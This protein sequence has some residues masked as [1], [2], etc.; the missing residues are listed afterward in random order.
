M[1]PF[2]VAEYQERLERVRKNMEKQG[3]EVLLITDPANM[4]YLSGY[5]AWSFYVHQMLVVDLSSEQ[6]IWIGRF[7]DSGAARVTTWMHD[8]YIIGYPDT[9]VHSDVLHPMMYAA[10][11]LKLKGL[12]NKRI[13]VEMDHYYF[14]A[15]AYFHLQ[16]ELPDADLT[17]ADLLV[18][19]VRLI[20]SDQEIEYMKKAARLAE[21]AMT[22][23]VNSIRAGKRECDA[24]AMIYYHM[25]AG[26][27]DISGD[28]P[29][30][31]P[32]LP[33]GKNTSNPHLTW[34]DRTFQEGETV[35][36]ELAGCCKRYHVPLARTVTIGAP[37]KLMAGL[38]SVAVEGLNKVLDGIKPGMTCG[39]AEAL[40]RKAL[41]KHGIV[42]E[43]RLGY[44]VGLNY[45]PDWGEHTASIRNGDRTVLKP[46]MTFH[47]IPGL[48]F[49]DYG[50]EISETIRITENGCETFTSFPRE[51][52]INMPSAFE[53]HGE[54]S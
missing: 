27:K 29:A 28:Y 15:K 16:K 18:N 21:T 43:S 53:E 31:V 23:G 54:I 35:I 39:E 41:K 44:S 26:T 46:N 12:G 10:D 9:Y 25:I 30:I 50:M 13:G 24:A 8:D 32:L 33:T 20:K 48:W 1:L 17:D 34:T 52:L 49:D 2:E 36:V 19:N 22:N 42:K 38:A 5:D 51:L 11:I 4:N 3:V 14:T 7:M 45:P 37:S 6:P 40:W 47:L